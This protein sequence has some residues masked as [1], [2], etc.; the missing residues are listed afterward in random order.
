[1]TKK[2]LIVITLLLTIIEPS[3]AAQDRTDRTTTTATVTDDEVKI[4]ILSWR[5]PLGFKKRWQATENYLT[6]TLDRK[7]TFLPLE[8]KEILPAV[9]AGEVDFF[10]ADPSMFISAKNEYG[11]SEVLTMKLSHTDSVGAVLFTRADNHKI[12]KL[13][14]LNQK[15][16]GALQRWSFGGWQMAEKE[17]RN[18]G[19]DPY[20]LL[21]TLRFFDKPQSVVYAVLSRKVDAGT[22]PASIL[23]RMVRIKKIDMA[24]IKIL[25]K[26]DH[27]GFPYVCSTELY[28][29]FPLAKTAA[30][31][32]KLADHLAAA[33]SDLQPKDKILQAARIKGWVAPLDY[34]PIE[35]V[36]SQLRGGGYTGRRY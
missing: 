11:A 19:I 36:Q 2:I 32:Q 9:K 6:Q 21:H 5:G 25:R 34:T 8:F 7:I 15:K 13:Y 10:T 29:S 3:F 16:F 1:M 14:D 31:D 18:A 17:F 35:V 27:P 30:T 23:E 4:G 33:L 28:P 24:D 20:S 22:V 26:K 12:N